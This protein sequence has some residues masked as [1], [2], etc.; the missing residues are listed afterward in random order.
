MMCLTMLG[1]G[2]QEYRKKKGIAPRDMAKAL[3]LSVEEL[4]RMECGGCPEPPDIRSRITRSY[5]DFLR[6][7]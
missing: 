4:C 2:L 5:P 7:M 3:D 6:L 1:D